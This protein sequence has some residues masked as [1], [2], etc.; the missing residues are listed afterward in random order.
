MDGYPHIGEQAVRSKGASFDHLE[1]EAA[2]NVWKI[3]LR[4]CCTTRDKQVN[5]HMVRI[6]KRAENF[7]SD[8]KGATAIEYGLIALVIVIPIIATTTVIGT[9]VLGMFTSVVNAF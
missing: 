3:V 7:L 1:L 9:R 8:N 4:Y 5:M 2:L 6:L